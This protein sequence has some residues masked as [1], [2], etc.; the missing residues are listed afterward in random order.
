M[1]SLHPETSSCSSPPITAGHCIH[2]NPGIRTTSRS[3][4]DGSG[5]HSLSRASITKFGEWDLGQVCE[6]HLNICARHP[7]ALIWL[8]CLTWFTENSFL[9]F[10]D[11]VDLTGVLGWRG[12]SSLWKDLSWWK[13]ARCRQMWRFIFRSNPF[14]LQR[15]VNLT[16]KDWLKAQNSLSKHSLMCLLCKYLFRQLLERTNPKLTNNWKWS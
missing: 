8:E 11:C 2:G 3:R 1:R 16:V 15:P 6:M 7:D 12:C 9:H 14:S 13:N 4:K 5:I 10:F